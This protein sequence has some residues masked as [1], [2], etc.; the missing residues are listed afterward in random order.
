MI[1]FTFLLSLFKK[2]HKN[3][4]QSHATLMMKKRISI[5]K[6]HFCLINVFSPS[7][8]FSSKA[9][10]KPA[11]HRFYISLTASESCFKIATPVAHKL[12]TDFPNAPD[13]VP[14]DQH[15]LC[16]RTLTEQAHCGRVHYSAGEAV[17]CQRE[18]A[19]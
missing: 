7:Y 4:K 3:K 8:S 12:N 16:T 6:S 18:E 15:A 13:S 2:P 14:Y 5:R 19:C 1:F 9:I 11:Y 10:A 17:V